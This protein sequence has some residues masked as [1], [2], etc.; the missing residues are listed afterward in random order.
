MPIP[1]LLPGLNMG[2]PGMGEASRNIAMSEDGSRIPIPRDQLKP[3]WVLP[4]DLVDE[5][6]C[7]KLKAGSRLTDRTIATL[8]VVPLYA[9]ANW[10]LEKNATPG[11]V[12]RQIAAQRGESLD[13]D[14]RRTHSRKK[15]S[16]AME[17]LVIEGRGDGAQHRKIKV[18]TTDI[19]LGGFAFY[20]DHFLHPGTALAAQFTALPSQP[21]LKGIVR[22]CISA[23]G[24][25]HRIGVQFIQREVVS[26]AA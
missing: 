6:G 24:M 22:S 15:W 14:D 11:S 13:D 12:V 26:D 17:V 1:P 8:G 25:K 10:P 2:E 21:V 9:G 19:S 5:N 16:V 7:V 23:G 4:G 20:F 18:E 3:G